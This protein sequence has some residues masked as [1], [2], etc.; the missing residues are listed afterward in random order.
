MEERPS[1]SQTMDKQMW[2]LAPTLQAPG[3]ALIPPPPP[4]PRGGA[5]T[6]R[7]QCFKQAIEKQVPQ[8][9]ALWEV[10]HEPDEEV[11]NDGQGCGEDD[12]GEGEGLSRGWMPKPQHLG[13]A[14]TAL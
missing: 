12:P 10:R 13:I 7:D 6:H 11:S 9:L 1:A 14:R 5:H 4:T 2:L 3:T 8:G